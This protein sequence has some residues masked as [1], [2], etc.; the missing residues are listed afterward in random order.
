MSETRTIIERDGLRLHQTKGPNAYLVV[1]RL[2][3]NREVVSAPCV[4]TEDKDEIIRLL[5]AAWLA[6][7]EP[8]ER[9]EPAAA[10]VPLPNCICPTTYAHGMIIPIADGDC[11][12]CFPK[13]A[14]PAV[15]REAEG[16]QG[17]P[18]LDRVEREIQQ[19]HYSILRGWLAIHG[20]ASARIALEEI[21]QLVR[22]LSSAPGERT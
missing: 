3:D 22:A 16:A 12:R 6:Y 4:V 18:L 21:C 8:A 20:G 9:S 17:V 1:T 14:A 7:A 2:S 13:P 15:S 11:P 10:S 5:F 19:G